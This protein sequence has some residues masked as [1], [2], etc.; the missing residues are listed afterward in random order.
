MVSV[1][2]V[3]DS[4]FMRTMLKDILVQGGHTV[5]GEAVD[6]GDAIEKYKETKPEMVLMDTI[7]PNMNGIEGVRGIV[8]HDPAARIIMCSAY[9]KDKTVIESFEAGALNYILKPFEPSHVLEIIDK[10]IDICEQ[11]E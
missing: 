2:V 5:V 10:V 6:G 11:A 3:D 7:M 9:G 1:L 4:L 8:E